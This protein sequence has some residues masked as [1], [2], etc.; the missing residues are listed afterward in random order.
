[1]QALDVNLPGA[2]VSDL[3]YWPNHWFG[4]ESANPNAYPLTHEQVV[5]YALLRSERVVPGCPMEPDL[6]FRLPG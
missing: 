3:I 4:D 1:M 6:P 2:G 5:R